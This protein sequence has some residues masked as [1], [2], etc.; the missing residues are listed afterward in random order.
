ML[1]NF[2]FDL[3]NSISP[4]DHDKI[5]EICL[6]D[7]TSARNILQRKFRENK[8]INVTLFIR[9]FENFIR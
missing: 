9:N 4:N 6:N 8:E 1:D 2:P 7:N 5:D 3:K